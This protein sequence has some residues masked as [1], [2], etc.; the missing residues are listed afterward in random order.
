MLF[1]S[2]YL[3]V[4]P[5]HFYS[6]SLAICNPMGTGASVVLDKP[7]RD[8]S[9][10]TPNKFS[11]T[12]FFIIIVQ[13]MASEV[14][15]K[16]LDSIDT[17][18]SKNTRGRSALSTWEHTRPPSNN[19]PIRNKKARLLFYCKY[20]TEPYAAQPTSNFR[21]HL[22]SKH[23]IAIEPETSR[24]KEAIRDQLKDLYLKVSS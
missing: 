22:V 14:E 24:T 17:S 4:F 6:S 16:A 18:E 9:W 11:V 7:Y 20:C 13:N 5:A 3:F 23:G 1:R 2:T 8:K 12:F 10:H 15:S 21:N 19:E